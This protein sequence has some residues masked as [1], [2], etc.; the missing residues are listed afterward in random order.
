ML[1]AFEFAL[2]LTPA[3]P[4]ILGLMIT[5]LDGFATSLQGLCQQGP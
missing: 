2:D 4:E 1:M 3:L 5:V